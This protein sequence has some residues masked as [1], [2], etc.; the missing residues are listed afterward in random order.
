MF[1]NLIG[2]EK[3]KKI[4]ES[5]INSK[6]FPH[7]YLFM[8]Q[9]G[10]GKR[11]C[12]VEFAKILNCM[13]AES[14]AD[15]SLADD[16]LF[17]APQSSPAKDS[18]A[19]TIPCNKCRSC[20]K[21]SKNIHPD[22][23]FIDFEKQ[24]QLLA[25]PEKKGEELSLKAKQ[26]RTLGIELIKNMQ[27]QAFMKAYE[28]TWKVF[29]IDPAEKMTS[30]AAN[31]LLKTLEEPPENTIIFLIA[32]H[33]ATIPATIVSRCQILFFAPLKQEDLAA[34]LVSNM[35]LDEAQA[36]KIAALSEGSIENAQNLLDKNNEEVLELWEKMRDGGL[37]RMDICDILALAGLVPRDEG[38][39][40]IDALSA[41]AKLQFRKSPKETAF[42]LEALNA[43]RALL[44]KNVNARLVFDV[45]FLSLGGKI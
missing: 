40:Y 29:I 17:A 11:F 7:A 18:P 27:S 5:Q 33:K 6:K 28:S 22:I 32:R 19:A 3:V 35:N 15:E 30:E 34:Y 38:I 41:Q 10:V 45:L 37:K 13:G 4:L 23:H 31:C 2:Q 26:R 43:S 1:E 42:I 44:L 20:I 21:I 36:Q 25:K 9:E 8:G 12:A 16:L 39:E 14:A 24:A